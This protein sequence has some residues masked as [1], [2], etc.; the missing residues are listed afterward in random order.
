[1]FFHAKYANIIHIPPVFVIY[2]GENLALTFFVHFDFWRKNRGYKNRIFCKFRN[3]KNRVET[4]NFC[5]NVAKCRFGDRRKMMYICIKLKEGSSA[6][7]FCDLSPENFLWRRIFFLLSRNFFLLRKTFF[8]LR[9]KNSRCFP[10]K[11]VKQRKFFL[12][13]VK[14]LNFFTF[15][16]MLR[17]VKN[18]IN[19]IL[20]NFVDSKRV[21]EV[22]VDKMVW[23]ERLFAFRTEVVLYTLCSV[24]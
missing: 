6:L 24:L 11:I 7:L 21:D 23:L 8:F 9:R 5:K 17:D 13:E 18:C 16:A 12:T 10:K 2:Y 3:S 20:Q 1:M 22:R 14:V 4:V 15:W 19:E